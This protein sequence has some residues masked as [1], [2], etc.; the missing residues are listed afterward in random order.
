MNLYKWLLLPLAAL[1]FYT[2]GQSIAPHEAT[3]EITQGEEFTDQ[4]RRVWRSWR[5]TAGI[6]RKCLS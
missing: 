6:G 5:R 1:S 2:H 4:Q 3:T